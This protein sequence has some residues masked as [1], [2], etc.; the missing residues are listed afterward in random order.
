VVRPA[1]GGNPTAKS[2]QEPRAN[3]KIIEGKTH[4]EALL[5]L[6]RPDQRTAIHAQ[7]LAGVRCPALAPCGCHTERRN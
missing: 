4:K 7:L 5:T 1:V 3:P 6:K 2:R